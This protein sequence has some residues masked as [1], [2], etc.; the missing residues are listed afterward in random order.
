MVDDIF[1]DF[2]LILRARCS[3]AYLSK[4]VAEVVIVLY[5]V[6]RLVGSIRVFEAKTSGLRW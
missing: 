5:G 6:F 4:N 3:R 1:L 2:G